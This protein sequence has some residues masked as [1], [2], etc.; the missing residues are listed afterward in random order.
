MEPGARGILAIDN[1]PDDLGRLVSQF[2]EEVFCIATAPGCDCTELA[3]SFLERIR[4]R[5][6]ATLVVD[7]ILE[8]DIWGGLRILRLATKNDLIRGRKVVIWSRYLLAFEAYRQTIEDELREAGA[9]S[10]II[11]DKDEVPHW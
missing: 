10:I 6:P 11:F 5:D 2:G 4:E 8:T 1:D 9:E 3:Q 7:L